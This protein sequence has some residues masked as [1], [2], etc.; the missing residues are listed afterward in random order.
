MI[1]NNYK[2]ANSYFVNILILIVKQFIY[3]KKCKG[4]I[5]RFLDIT[6]KIQLC[7]LC[8]GYGSILLN[9]R[10]LRF[11]SGESML[12]RN[13]L[14]GIY[15]LMNFYLVQKAKTKV[16]T[17]SVKIFDKTDISILNLE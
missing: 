13:S 3:A 15:F 8:N 16:K 14:R 10:I 2:G 17:E 7:Y 1:L 5:P 4:T 6:T 12:T 11:D 9:Y